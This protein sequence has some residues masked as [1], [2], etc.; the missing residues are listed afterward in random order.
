MIIKEKLIVSNK[1]SLTIHDIMQFSEDS[2]QYPEPQMNVTNLRTQFYN[3]KYY[4]TQNFF[5]PFFEAGKT[6]TPSDLMG[7]S[8]GKFYVPRATKAFFKTCPSPNNTK[9]CRNPDIP[10]PVK[11]DLAQNNWQDLLFE[12]YVVE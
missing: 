11:E 7:V 3:Q 4:S 6:P 12:V 1:G 10:T 8:N 9:S 5:L 2:V